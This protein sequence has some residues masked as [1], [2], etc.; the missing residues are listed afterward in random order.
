MGGRGHVLFVVA[1]TQELEALV[2]IKGAQKIPPTYRGRAI[3]CLPYLEGGRGGGDTTCFGHTI[4]PVCSP[5][6]SP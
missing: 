3:F 2:I 1:L 6:P 5:P 4:Y